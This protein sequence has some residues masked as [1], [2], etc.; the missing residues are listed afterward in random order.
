MVGLTIVAGLVLTMFQGASD[1]DSTSSATA[2]WLRVIG[3]A[4][5]IAAG[6]RK[7]RTRPRGDDEV[8]PPRWMAS[9]D[10]ASVGRAAVL[11]AALSGANPKNLVLAA[12]ATTA[13]IET[14]VHGPDL[15]V[16]VVV[17]LAVA[18]ST[19]IGAVVLHLLGGA[20]AAGFL[21]SVR[22]FMVANNTAIMVV[23]L[24]LIGANVLGSGLE[25]LGR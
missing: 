8:E 4:A 2:D 5:L 10:D 20:R 11:G 25:G 13:I 22:G 9:L 3:G 24:V 1:P 23:I 15:T 19:V 6:A 14:G 21:D 17:F 18:S 16:A 12:A 7:W